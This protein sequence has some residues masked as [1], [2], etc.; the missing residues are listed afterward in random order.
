MS[1]IALFTITAGFIALASGC[2]GGP[3]GG[4]RPLA[5]YNY[6]PVYPT[7]YAPAYSTAY[8]YGGP[9]QGGCNSC[10]GGVAPF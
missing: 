8:N 4:G 10:A 2:C 3:C 5:A 1:R 9:V 6:N 7:A